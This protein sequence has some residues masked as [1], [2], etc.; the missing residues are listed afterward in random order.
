MPYDAIVVSRLG[1]R[2]KRFLS[3]LRWSLRSMFEE[4]LGE[5][6]C[7]RDLEMPGLC[8]NTKVYLLESSM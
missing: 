1:C 3:A 6:P 2:Y 8:Q 7:P 4:R 5:F